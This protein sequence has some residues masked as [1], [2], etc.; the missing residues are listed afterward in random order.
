MF[1]SN[2]FSLFGNLNIL[3]IIDKELTILQYFSNF[4]HESI[5]LPKH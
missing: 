1:M 2:E 5:N 4:R 3:Y